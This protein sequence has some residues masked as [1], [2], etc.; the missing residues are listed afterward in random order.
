M[1]GNAVFTGAG[2]GSGAGLG[3]GPALGE[4]PGPAVAGALGLGEGGAGEVEA[5]T[6]PA[7]L[8]GPISRRQ[9]SSPAIA[10]TSTAA[11]GQNGVRERAA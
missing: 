4:D 6:S 5:T 2:L 11:T 10:T 1:P 7:G 9:A 8:K 3:L